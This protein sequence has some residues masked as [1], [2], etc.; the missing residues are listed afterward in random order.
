MADVYVPGI[1]KRGQE[2]SSIV[3]DENLSNNAPGLGKSEAR[4]LQ[5]VAEWPVEMSSEHAS[6]GD[7]IGEDAR[8]A[9]QSDEFKGEHR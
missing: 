6:G 9:A 8:E 3:L 2:V 7:N 1:G 4:G 5:T